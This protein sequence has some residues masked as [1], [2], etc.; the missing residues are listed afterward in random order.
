TVVSSGRGEMV[1]ETTG[2]KTE[3]GKIALS[4]QEPSEET[5]L[6]KQLSRFSKQLSYL[7]LTLVIFV[8]LVGF[9][10]RM[11]L[12]VLFKTSVALAVSSIPE[13]IL[14][15]LTIVLAIGMQRI[16]K[17]KG[18]VR[19]LISAE[20]LGG[21]T[22]ICID[23][24]GTLTEGKQQ[25][26]EFEFIKNI[27][28]KEYIESLVLAVERLSNHPVSVAGVTY[29][30]KKDVVKK[31]AEKVVVK[32]F[33]AVSGLGVRAQ[34]DEHEL[35]IGADR[36]FKKEGIEIPQTL[37]TCALDWQK[38][39]RTV[40]FVSVDKKVVGLFCIADAIRKEVP[41]AIATLKK[42]GIESI[43]ITGDNPVS[44]KS[45]ADAVGIQKVFAQVLP[46]DKELHVRSL[47]DQGHIVAMVGDGINDAPALAAANIGIAIGEGTDVALETA[48]AALLRSDIMLVPRLIALSKAT[49]RNI[50]QNLIWAFGYNVLLIP[51][52]MG[53][54]Y[55][56]FG[57]TLNPMFAGAAMAF[58]SLSVVLNSLR[59]KRIKI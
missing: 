39:A 58:S 45:V 7:V 38:T 46:Q 48:G 44:A 1:V 8:F 20:T 50:T 51:V 6:K 53:I 49:M 32:N 55:P 13:G 4:I 59:L 9:L 21:V 11:E 19:N 52:A 26:Q 15:G 31:A 41:A 37:K 5:P 29:L 28:K 30:E 10:K 14:V 3:M 57:I 56:F 23:K 27:E 43:M 16:L 12:S 40:S 25:V 33:A 18:L 36:L 34:A 2:E 54:L 17:R 47:M 42:S 22:T 35:L 24:T